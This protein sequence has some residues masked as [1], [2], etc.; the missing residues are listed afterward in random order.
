MPMVG[1]GIYGW[2]AGHRLPTFFSGLSDN[3]SAA[4]DPGNSW[5]RAGHSALKMRAEDRS[6]PLDRRDAAL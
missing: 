4:D 6:T 3:E 5:R 2:A 1:S